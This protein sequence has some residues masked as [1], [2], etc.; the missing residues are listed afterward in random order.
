[1]PTKHSCQPLPTVVDHPLHVRLWSQT[2]ARCNQPTWFGDDASDFLDVRS[3]GPP[4]EV[5]EVTAQ[6]IGWQRNIRVRDAQG[7]MPPPPPSFTEQVL[8][9]ELYSRWQR[10]E[11]RQGQRVDASNIG[12]ATQVGA[13]AGVGVRAELESEPSLD[14]ERGVNRTHQPSS[15]RMR[16]VLRLVAECRVKVMLGWRRSIVR[17]PALCVPISQTHSQVR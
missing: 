16:K 12:N 3:P 1:M 17:P 11:S 2:M 13:G 5:Y 4:G 8:G 14:L 9:P 7:V 10:V 15:K 6:D